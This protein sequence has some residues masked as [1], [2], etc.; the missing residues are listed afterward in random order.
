MCIV[1]VVSVY[2]HCGQCLLSLWSVFTVIVASV[3]CHY[4]QCLLSLWSVFSV[5]EGN[6]VYFKS[7]QCFIFINVVIFSIDMF[8]E[9]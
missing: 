4:G 5:I 6:I 1:I 3:Y 9:D 2:C 8:M 7:G